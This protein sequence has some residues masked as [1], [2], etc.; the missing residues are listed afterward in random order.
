[1]ATID[2]HGYLIRKVQCKGKNCNS[3][4]TTRNWWL[5]KEYFNRKRNHIFASI[6][7]SIRIPEKYIGKKVR[8]KIEVIEDESFVKD[9]K[10]EKS[11]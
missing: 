11:L 8:F 2:E 4:G 7:L 6:I 10:E 9:N 1:M 3:S 5:I